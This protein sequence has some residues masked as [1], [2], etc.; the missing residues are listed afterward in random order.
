MNFKFEWPEIN[1]ISG[2]FLYA[3]IGYVL[4]FLVG[5]FFKPTK[6]EIEKE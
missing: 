2:M 3:M 4:V 1:S 6:E 5:Y